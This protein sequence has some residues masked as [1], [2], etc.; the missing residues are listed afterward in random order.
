MAGRGYGPVIRGAQT[1]WARGYIGA[2]VDVAVIDTGVAPVP[3][4]D[5]PGKV[6]T[7]P[8]LSCGSQQLWPQGVDAFGHGT[9]M[10]LTSE[11]FSPNAASERQPREDLH[12]GALGL[13]R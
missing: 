8:D 4:L 3:G 9:F 6:I 5:T 12:R 7:G 13:A 11:M 1:A 10:T 2:G